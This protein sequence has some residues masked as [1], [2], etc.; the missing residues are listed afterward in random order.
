MKVYIVLHETMYK[1]NIYYYTR[2]YTITTNI[3]VIQD[4]IFLIIYRLVSQEC[5]LH[6]SV[7]FILH[8]DVEC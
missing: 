7:F 8:N 1:E 6:E 3:L 2:R 4:D 5:L